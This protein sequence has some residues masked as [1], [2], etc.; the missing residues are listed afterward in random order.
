MAAI[1][2]VEI[3]V[4][5]NKVRVPRIGLGTMSMS[6]VYGPVDDEES[7]KVLERA[8]EIGCTLWN[9]ASLYGLGH[10]ERLLSRVLKSSRDKVFLTTKFG[11]EFREPE[12][13]PPKAFLNYI[14]GHNGKRDFVRKSLDG[15]LDR[16]GTDYIDMF[17]IGRID[18]STPLEETVGAMAELVKKGKIRYIG[19]SECT[20]EDLRLAYKV[21]PIAAVEVEY[22][23]W[24]RDIET[25]GL[26]DAC[27]EL[28]VTV[29]AY[30]PLGHGFLTGRV[31]NTEELDKSDFRQNLVRFQTGKIETN[32]KFVNSLDSLAKKYNATT[33]QLALAWL[34]E[35]EKNLVVIPGTKKINYLEENFGAGKVKLSDADLEELN[36]LVDGADIQ[37]HRLWDGQE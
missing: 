37:G 20:A 35:K 12:D 34:L 21:H 27:R 36:K 26:L 2:T 10:N 25:D 11:V 17:I 32:L 14:T 24:T 19:I 1:P 6:T 4:P 15:A 7:V 31:H 30:S 8:V 23:M 33:G 18:R 3:G 29:I 22:S 13:D 28:G 9:S 5:G 16:L